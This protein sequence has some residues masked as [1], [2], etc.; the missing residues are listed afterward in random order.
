MQGCLSLDL[1]LVHVPDVQQLIDLISDLLA[2][3]LSPPI[4]QLTSNSS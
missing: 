3:G 4:F 2:P 1:V